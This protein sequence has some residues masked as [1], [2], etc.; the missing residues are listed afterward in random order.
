MK[1]DGDWFIA[2]A[3]LSADADQMVT[4]HSPKNIPLMTRRLLLVHGTLVE[5]EL[6]TLKDVTVN[7][8]G[9]S[10]AGSDDGEET[11]SLELLLEGGLDL[12]VG[13]EALSV[14]L[15]D[16]LGLLLLLDDLTGLGLA[17]ATEVGTVVSLVPLAEWNGIDLDDRGLGQ[18]V[19]ADQL[20][21]GWMESDANDADLAGNTLRSPG[22][23]AGVE[24]ESTELAVTTTGADK[25]NTLGTDTGVG[26]LTAGLESALLPWKVIRTCSG[27]NV[28]PQDILSEFADRYGLSVY[29][30]IW[31]MGRTVVGTLGTG[32]AAL[33]AGV[34][35]NTHICESAREKMLAMDSG[36][37]V[38]GG[39]LR[40][41]S[42]DGSKAGRPGVI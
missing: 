16:G 25:V 28:L 5:S 34:T 13:G 38:E 7:T 23:V 3:H 21:V 36:I 9:L 42:R 24:T 27:W 22:E 29:S 30:W 10:W 4:I 11:T 18:G 31:S 19:G 15:L 35:R 37:V 14:L 12:A 8:A 40:S 20:V 33:V 41:R 1:S 2:S 6:L 39:L 32:G 17:A 26:W